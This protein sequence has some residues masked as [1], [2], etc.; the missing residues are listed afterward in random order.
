MTQRQLFGSGGLEHLRAYRPI[1]DAP[2]VR[3]L[4]GAGAIIIG[5]TETDPGAFSTDTPQ[6]T[7]PLARNR[8][9]G[10]S[11]GGSAAA[12]AAGM[13]FAAIGTDTGGSIRVPAACCSLCGSNPPGAGWTQQAFAHL[14]GPLIMLGHWPVAFRI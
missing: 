10:G 3:A 12:V 13:A 1:V 7:N 5:V 6:V 4:R 8:T 14:Q 11:S 9:A 2:V